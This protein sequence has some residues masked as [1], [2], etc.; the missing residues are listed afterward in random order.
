MLL[1]KI[2]C[3][4]LLNHVSHVACQC[5]YN[6]RFARSEHRSGLAILHELPIP[7]QGGVCQLMN[8]VTMSHSQVR[9][10]RFSDYG[11]LNAGGMPASQAGNSRSSVTELVC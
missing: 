2:S 1:P 4:Q 6:V 9:L 7:P 10:Y 3:V 8:T 5:A 11:M